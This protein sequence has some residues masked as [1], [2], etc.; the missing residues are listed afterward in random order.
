MERNAIAILLLAASAHG[1]AAEEQLPEEVQVTG[2]RQLY[3]LQEQVIE[4]EDAV[5]ALYNELNQDDLYDINC[6]WLKP[7]GTNLKHH[8]C[9]PGFIS[10]AERSR[11]QE[12]MSGINGLGFTT[13]TTVAVDHALHNPILKEKLIEAVKSSPELEALMREHQDLKAILDERKAG[14]FKGN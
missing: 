7:L 11:G 14:M 1:L 4:A 8:V 3:L 10:R 5:Y 13:G 12:Y 2:Q 6:E 9:R